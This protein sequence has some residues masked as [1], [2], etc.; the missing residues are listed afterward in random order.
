MLLICERHFTLFFSESQYDR[1]NLL[2]VPNEDIWI[3]VSYN[4]GSALRFA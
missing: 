2:H 3:H 1:H 4:N